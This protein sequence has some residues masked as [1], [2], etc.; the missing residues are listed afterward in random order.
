M[1]DDS[2]LLWSLARIFG[3]APKDL[4]IGSALSPTQ[5]EEATKKANANVLRGPIMDDFGYNERKPLPWDHALGTGQTLTPPPPPGALLHHPNPQ[6][7]PPLI[8]GAQA[9]AFHAVQPCSVAVNWGDSWNSLLEK[10]FEAY[11]AQTGDDERSVQRFVEAAK[12]L[13]ESSEAGAGTQ[14]VKEETEEEDK[15]FLL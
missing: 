9:V 11:K 14:V 3:N 13:A 10:A 2:P 15:K 6:P 4:P 12:R 8:L 7:G 5:V 1:P